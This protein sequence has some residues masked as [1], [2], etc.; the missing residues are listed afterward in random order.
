MN[1]KQKL[2]LSLERDDFVL[3]HWVHQK[4]LVERNNL[5]VLEKLEHRA[6]YGRGRCQGITSELTCSSIQY[7]RELIPIL[8][9]P[10]VTSGW[11]KRKM[12]ACWIQLG[13]MQRGA[14]E[15]LWVGCRV[16]VTNL[17]RNAW[18]R[19]PATNHV[20]MRGWTG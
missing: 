8:L 16:Q 12:R 11:S 6:N 7:K 17:Y 14:S 19:R 20:R 10:R 4:D 2:L 1:R 15:L 3:V 18:F 13:T 5:V 9:L